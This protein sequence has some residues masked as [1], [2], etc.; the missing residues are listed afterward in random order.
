MAS[1]TTVPKLRQLAAAIE[2][3]VAKIQEA[4][5]AQG[6]PSPSFDEDAPALPSDIGEARDVVLDATAELQD[7]LTEPLNM[8]HRASRVRSSSRSIVC[9]GVKG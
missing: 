9:I 7:L 1:S 2:A 3:A 8:I 5:D 4:L 6:V